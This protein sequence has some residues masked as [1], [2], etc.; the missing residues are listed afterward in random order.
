MLETA[1]L[2]S[3]YAV[4]AELPIPGNIS[5]VSQLQRPVHYISSLTS[6]TNT[7]TTRA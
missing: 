1:G 7:G 5:T 2:Y 4:V 6:T 3:H